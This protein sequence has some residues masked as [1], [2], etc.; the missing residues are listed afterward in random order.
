MSNR[1]AKRWNCY[2]QLALLTGACVLLSGCEAKFVDTRPLSERPQ[3]AAIDFAFT[4]PDLL[5]TDA[6]PLGSELAA[7]T[8]TGRAGHG[9]SGSAQL[10][11]RADGVV[12][13]RLL[14]DFSVTPVPGPA[15]FLT[16]RTDMGNTI[17]PQTDLNLGTLQSASGAQSYAVPTDD[18]TRRNVFVFCQPFRVEVAKAALVNK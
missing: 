12:E 17:D 16:S 13:V 14:M 9:G 10:Y 2:T 15:I 7:G 6:S 5:G 1:Q 8:F 18:G 3:T 4:P 11:R